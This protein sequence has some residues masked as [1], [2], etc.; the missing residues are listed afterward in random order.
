MRPCSPC[1]EHDHAASA[2]QY[3]RHVLVSVAAAAAA[4][5]ILIM[6]RTPPSVQSWRVIS[7]L[8]LFI[9]ESDR[10]PYSLQHSFQIPHV[11]STYSATI[12]RVHYYLSCNLVCCTLVIYMPCSL[13]PPRAQSVNIGNCY[14]HDTYVINVS[15]TPHFPSQVTLCLLGPVDTTAISIRV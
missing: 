4:A 3:L 1:R 5:A 15:T 9:L 7:V 13:L 6:H 14:L 8:L 11:S 10:Y 2:G 12:S